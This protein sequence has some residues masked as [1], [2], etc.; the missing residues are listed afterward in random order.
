M[1]HS[2]LTNRIRLSAQSDSRNGRQIDRFIVHHAASTSL[3]GVVDMMVRETREVS[4]NYVVG[5]QIVCVVDEELRAWTSGTADWDGRAITVETINNAGDPNWTV[6]DKTFDNLARLIADC[7]RRYGFPI[8]DDTIL[9]H[10]ELYRRYGDSYATACPG[11]LQRR[12]AELIGLANS[13]LSNQSRKDI[14]MALTDQE[15]KRLLAKV[16]LLAYAMDKILLPALARVDKGTYAN[17]QTNEQVK[18]ELEAFSARLNA[19][20]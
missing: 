9:T 13:Y 12:K 6:S 10:Q 1:T 19:L 4:A 17:Q 3:D 20:K 5:N 18:S 8:T 11:D 15:Q 7:A 16:D 2:P 14:F